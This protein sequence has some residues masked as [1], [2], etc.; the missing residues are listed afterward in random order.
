M[1]SPSGI[2]R[3]CCRRGAP[4]EL[5]TL[6]SSGGPFPNPPPPAPKEKPSPVT[7]YPQNSNGVGS[8]PP[9]QV[10][11]AVLTLFLALLPFSL[12]ARCSTSW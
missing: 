7:F 11:G 3:R 2:A 8:Q 10:F 5:S 4:R 1:S 6:L 12:L 9:S